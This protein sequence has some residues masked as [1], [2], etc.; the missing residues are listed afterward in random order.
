MA[1]RLHRTAPLGLSLLV[2]E[3]GE[4]IGITFPR[5]AP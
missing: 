2:I 1:I 3:E 5:L 4:E